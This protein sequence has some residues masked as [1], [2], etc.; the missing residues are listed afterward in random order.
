M[1]GIQGAKMSLDGSLFIETIS[2]T[3]TLIVS[4]GT[5]QRVS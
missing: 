3:D 1:A 2:I 4:Y 5:C